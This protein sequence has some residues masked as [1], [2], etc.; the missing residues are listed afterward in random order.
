MS[1]ATSLLAD[2]EA[3]RTVPAGIGSSLTE[4]QVV[5]D[6]WND[7]KDRRRAIS[8][9]AGKDKRRRQTEVLADTRHRLRIIR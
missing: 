4:A 9:A 5:P 3:V 2:K 7:L 8:I 1:I 6:R